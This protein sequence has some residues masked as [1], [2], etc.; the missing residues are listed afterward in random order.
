MRSP[1]RLRRTMT[2]GARS[3]RGGGILLFLLAVVAWLIYVGVRLVLSLI[4]ITFRYGLPILMTGFALA[5]RH[6]VGSGRPRPVSGSGARHV[7]LSSRRDDPARVLDRVIRDTSAAILDAREQVSH[8]QHGQSQL[9]S[10]A[11]HYRSVA[12]GCEMEAI[13]AV[14]S[15]RDDLARD[16]L[17][18]KLA[19]EAGAREREAHLEARDRVLAGLRISLGQLE[20]R[21]EDA[22]RK[23]ETVRAYQQHARLRERVISAHARMER[24]DAL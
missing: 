18:R 7:A 5:F 1:R 6:V 20:E 2:L 8:L 14:Q 24:L 13:L 4:L 9:R 11:E 19:C 12:R 21:R 3:G 17:R 10:E 23:R 22:V 15:D 16:A